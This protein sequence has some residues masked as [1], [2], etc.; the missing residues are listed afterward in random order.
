[1]SPPLS[2]KSDATF[3]E[4]QRACEKTNANL[5]TLKHIFLSVITTEATQ[6]VVDKIY[7]K[8]TGFASRG[9]ADFPVW[10]QRITVEPD[11]DEF[12]ALLASIQVKGIVWMLLQHREQ[13]GQKTITKMSVFKDE[14]TGEPG[15]DALHRG[16]CL[17]I[18][19]GDMQSGAGKTGAG[20]SGAGPS[21]AGPSGAGPSGAGP[22]VAGK[23]GAE[24]PPA[25]EPDPKRQKIGR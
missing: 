22:S 18:E 25:G 17:Y 12:L 23:K 13:L 10:N 3:L 19:L 9:W 2:H 14:V 20:P 15:Y 6:Q 16:P 4:W 11:S 21:G 8:K 7:A 24:Q 1:V 5:K